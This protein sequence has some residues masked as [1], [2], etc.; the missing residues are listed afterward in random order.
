MPIDQARAL[1]LQLPSYDVLLERGRL[2]AFAAAVGESDPLSLDV[3][4]ARAAGHPDI[5]ALPTYL[6]SIELEAPDPLGYLDEIGA[7][8]RGILHGEQSFAYHAMVFAGDTITVRPRIVEAYAKND[9]MDFV[10]KHTDFLRGDELVGEADALI[11]AWA[12]VA[13]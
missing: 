7:D 11:V 12:V 4:A 2:R 8:L 5:P 13:A 10:V 9:R 6:F 1:A 3:A